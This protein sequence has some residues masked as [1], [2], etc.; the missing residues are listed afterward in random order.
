MIDVLLARVTYMGAVALIAIG[1]YVLVDDQH[2]V[3]KV[4]G[5]NIFQTGVFLF[6]IGAGYRTGGA[7]PIVSPGGGPYVN[8]LPQVLM[9]T[10][11]VVGV[12]VTAVALALI[13]RIHGEYGTV[14]EDELREVLADE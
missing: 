5:L 14:R 12:A 8:P 3:K 1:L 13:V 7:P 4:F 11:I 10:A 2:L 6:F 9:L